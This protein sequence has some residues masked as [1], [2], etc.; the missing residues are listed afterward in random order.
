MADSQLT[1]GFLR[2]GYS[3]TGGVEAY[4]KG[5]AEGLRGEGH[6]VVL[7]GTSEWPKAEWPGGEIIRCKGGSLSQYSAEVTRQKASPD[8]RFDL[9]LSVEKV[10]G[11]DL[12]RTDEGLHAAWIEQR[13]RHIG[14]WA[15]F[16][17]KISPKH[18]EKLRLERQLFTPEKT[19]R[20]ISLSHKISGEISA[21]YGYPEEQITLIRNGVPS[22]EATTHEEREIARR[23]LGIPADEKVVLF[24]G[25][26]WERK[27]LRFA[28]DAVESLR[29][30]MV[31]LF[32]AGK[33][34]EKRYASPSVRFLGSVSQMATIY[35]AADIILFPTIFDPFPLATLEAL[36]AGL[37]VITTAANGVSEIMTPGVHGE[38]IAESSDSAALVTALHKW[39]GILSDP[40]QA[41]QARNACAALASE[42]TLERNLKETLAVIREVIAE[43]E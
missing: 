14:L 2:R 8:N 12:Y 30:P 27:G 23:K 10:P 17:Q 35:Y 9:I 26:G 19:R 39:L 29:D 16:F 25:T 3:P 42:F 43:R 5:L 1:I 28:I 6:R 7:L 20:V 15:R 32:V 38:V 40:V 31:K 21:L 4:L 24:V 22:R 41:D 37:P 13:S 18:R 34:N 11:C 36:S 33:G